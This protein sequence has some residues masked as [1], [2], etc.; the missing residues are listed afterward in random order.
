[1]AFAISTWG[2]KIAVYCLLSRQSFISVRMHRFISTNPSH[3]LSRAVSAASTLLLGLEICH[4]GISWHFYCF[5]GSHPTIG[6]L[7]VY[8]LHRWDG[9]LCRSTFFLCR[10]C[11]CSYLA[12]EWP[13]AEDYSFAL[14][15]LVYDLQVFLHNEVVVSSSTFQLRKLK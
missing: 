9:P 15:L 4:S 8:D 6:T 13:D 10:P 5:C 12:P 1:M 11:C 2:N 3:D 7:V 14:N